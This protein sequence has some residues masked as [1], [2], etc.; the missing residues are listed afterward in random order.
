MSATL[1]L[2]D[3]LRCLVSLAT[4]GIGGCSSSSTSFNGM[5]RH[6]SGALEGAPSG[7]RHLN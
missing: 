5:I 2:A 4:N 6:R 7:Y 3:E 1:R